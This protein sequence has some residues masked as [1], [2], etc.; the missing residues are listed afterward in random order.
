MRARTSVD[1][2]PVPHLIIEGVCDM[3]TGYKY[4]AICVSVHVYSDGYAE[5]FR[6]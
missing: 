5:K 6:E 2:F 4:L 1:G 3:I